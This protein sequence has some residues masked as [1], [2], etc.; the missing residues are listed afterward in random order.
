MIARAL[1][2]TVWF[3]PALAGALEPRFDHRDQQG[4]TAEALWIKDVIWTGS[5]SMSAQRAAVRA[6][7]GFDPTGDGNEL[8]FGS[9]FTVVEGASTGTDR[10]KVSLDA[11]YRA[12]VGTEELKTILDVGLWGSLTERVAVGP[13]IGLGFMYDFNRNFGLLTTGFLAGGA[14]NSRIVSF[15]GGVGLQFRYE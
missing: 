5:R 9:T 12:V 15:G 13:L 2:C 6:A 14:G 4:P 7:W 8:S 1:A 11:R 3:L 10:V